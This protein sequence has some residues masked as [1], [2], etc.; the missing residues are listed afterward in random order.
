MT[1]KPEPYVTRAAIGTLAREILGPRRPDETI[2]SFT[3]REARA[4]D[5]A[6]LSLITKARADAAKAA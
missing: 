4:L 5:E 2:F 6:R 1:F 3:R